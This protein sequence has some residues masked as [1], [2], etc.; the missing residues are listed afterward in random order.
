MSELTGENH[1]LGTKPEPTEEQPQEAFEPKGGCGEDGD[2]D[3]TAVLVAGP[4]GEGFGQEPDVDPEE[5]KRFALEVKLQAGDLFRAGRYQEAL[6][7]YYRAAD[8]MPE[9]FKEDKAIIYSNLGITLIKLQRYEEAEHECSTALEF[10]PEFVKAQANRAESRYHLKKYQ[11]SLEG[12]L[13]RLG[14]RRR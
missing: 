11:K 3:D 9:Q 7:G 2:G 13:S 5:A 4:T 8:K 1:E 12:E 10:N 14:R 6:E